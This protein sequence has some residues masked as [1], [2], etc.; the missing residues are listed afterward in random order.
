MSASTRWRGVLSAM[1]E[2]CWRTIA[3]RL[4]VVAGER[5]DT[6]DRKGRTDN[7]PEGI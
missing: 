2:P 6:D 4:K 7:G 5:I 3:E 1:G